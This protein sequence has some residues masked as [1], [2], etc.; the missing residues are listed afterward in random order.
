MCFTMWRCKCTKI[1]Y[2]G[3]YSE[4]F[5]TKK[6]KNSHTISSDTM[7]TSIKYSKLIV[8]LCKGKSTKE[9]GCIKLLRQFLS[10]KICSQSSCK[11][12]VRF[13]TA[14]PKDSSLEKYEGRG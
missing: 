5:V 14:Y 7:L 1:E 6:K 3:K 9:Q 10:L 4:L 2:N 13:Y 12:N 11:E 8:Y